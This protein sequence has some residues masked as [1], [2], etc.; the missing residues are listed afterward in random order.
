MKYQNWEKIFK[1]L[2][3]VVKTF[4]KRD[5]FNKKSNHPL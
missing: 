4:Q 5:I 3:L 2:I 1:R